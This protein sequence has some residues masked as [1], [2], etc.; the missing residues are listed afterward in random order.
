MSS[1]AARATTCCSATGQNDSIIGG[2][3]ADWISGGNGDDGILGDDGRLFMSRNSSAVPASRS[4][5]SRRSRR[6][7]STC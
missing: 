7:R 1:T 3:G 6:P 5:A 2:Y 4:M